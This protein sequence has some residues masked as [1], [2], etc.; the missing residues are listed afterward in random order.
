MTDEQKS[1]HSEFM[2]RRHREF[3]G[4]WQSRSHDERFW[5]NVSFPR[6]GRGCW[7]WEGGKFSNGYGRFSV[8]KRSS[9]LA[10]RWSLERR[11]GRPLSGFALHSCDVKHCVNPDHLR[12]GTQAENMADAIDRG[13]F[14]TNPAI[15]LR[16][17]RRVGSKLTDAAVREIRAQRG[18]S[19]ALD[20]A[21]RYSVSASLICHVW[22]GRAWGHVQ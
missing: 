12:E 18:I 8:G 1:G 10:H 5:S 13:R 3:C 7:L 15:H 14:K 16:G 21:K 22:N 19:T 4:R 11:L 9:I 20:L 6:G 2:K 17:E